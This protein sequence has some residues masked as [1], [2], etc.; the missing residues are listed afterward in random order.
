MQRSSKRLRVAMPRA[1][2]FRVPETR[3]PE[4]RTINTGP[5]AIWRLGLREATIKPASRRNGH[6]RKNPN[7]QREPRRLDQREMRGASSRVRPKR[8]FCAN[9]SPR[10]L[11]VPRNQ[12]IACDRMFDYEGDAAEA[13]LD[14]IADA[15]CDPR[16]RDEKN[17]GAHDRIHHGEDV[18]RA[19]AMSTPNEQ[20]PTNYARLY[21]CPP[22]V[23]GQF[24]ASRRIVVFFANRSRL[25]RAAAIDRRGR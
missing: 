15:V 18:G 8:V 9:A 12:V 22:R 17:H 6:R 20:S 24:A 25:N 14:Q 16:S 11:R 19:N 7:M 13:A 21:S 5:S 2:Q 3:A 23:F 1:P 10:R 4:L